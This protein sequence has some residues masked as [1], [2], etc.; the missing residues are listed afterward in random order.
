MGL[1]D[2]L[3]TKNTLV[4]SNRMTQQQ[5]Q[6]TMAPE[7]CLSLLLYLSSPTPGLV[8]M[9]RRVFVYASVFRIVRF[10]T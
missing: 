8:F 3:P 6:P 4:F 9:L 7:Q 2:D 10:R 1:G 5:D